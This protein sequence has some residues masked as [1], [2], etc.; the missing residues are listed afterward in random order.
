MGFAMKVS[1]PRDVR[2][3]ATARL[4]VAESAREAGCQRAPAEAFAGRVEDAARTCLSSSPSHPHVMMA[5]ERE[6]NALVVTIDH[7]VMRLAF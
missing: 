7:Q 4:I 3:A 5:V 1:L 6:P 2:Y